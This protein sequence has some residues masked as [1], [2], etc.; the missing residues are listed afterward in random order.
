MY[1]SMK[2]AK[3]VTALWIL[4]IP[5]TA[6]Q[7]INGS[8]TLLGNWDASGAATPK[9]AKTGTTPPA[10]CGVGEVFFNSSASPGANLY[11]CSATNSW[12]QVQ[13]T[14]TGAANFRQAFTSV[15]SVTLAHSLNTFGILFNCF[16]NGT[17]PLWIL[18]KSASLTDANTLTVTFA[19]LQSGSC[20]VNATGAGTSYTAGTGI[21]IAGTSLSVDKTSVPTYLAAA[22]SLSFG[23]IAQASC[24]QLTF[25]LT[26]ANPGDSIAPGWPS[27]IEAGLA[28]SMFVS[29][30]NTVA[31]RLC[32][33]SGSL[34]TP[35]AQTFRASVIRSFP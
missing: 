31:V 8:R 10:T 13:G 21:S 2:L 26:G 5:C 6:Q 1:S 19:S 35:A 33:L 16:D 28:G 29:A 32:N 15:T 24:A 18:P 23:S 20:V 9:P 12:T 7:I 27:T 22:S 25:A 17:P 14:S 30:S 3:A 34:L 4:A 11:L